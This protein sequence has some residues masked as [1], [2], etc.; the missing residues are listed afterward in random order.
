M[1]VEGLFHISL[2][3]MKMKAGPIETANLF[4]KFTHLRTTKHVRT[5]ILY[6][7]SHKGKSNL[8]EVVTLR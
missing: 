8:H 7:R 3:V 5:G 2:A 1:A 6:I 4:C